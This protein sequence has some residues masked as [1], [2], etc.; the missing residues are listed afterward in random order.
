MSASGTSGTPSNGTSNGSQNGSLAPFPGLTNHFQNSDIKFTVTQWP[1]LGTNFKDSRGSLRPYGNYQATYI[2]RGAEWTV[3]TTLD[4][5]DGALLYYIEGTKGTMSFT[6]KSGKSMT[7]LLKEA[8]E[9][10]IN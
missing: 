9:G 8:L 2:S 7:T 1:Q 10:I 5:G 6:R 4:E 3:G